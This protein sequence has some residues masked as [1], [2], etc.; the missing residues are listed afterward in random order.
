MGG[1]ATSC[2]TC[3]LRFDSGHMV[4]HL[5]VGKTFHQRSIV[6]CTHA[7]VDM[8]GMHRA[9]R[10]RPDVDAMILTW[11]FPSYDVIPCRIV[12]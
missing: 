1:S 3:S 7:M 12:R 9:A 10:N 8:L 2:T 5:L 4:S 11:G 6:D